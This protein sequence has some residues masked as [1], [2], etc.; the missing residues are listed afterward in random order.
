[1]KLP[2]SVYGLAFICGMAFLLLVA[3]ICALIILIS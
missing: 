1:M 3:L 2:E